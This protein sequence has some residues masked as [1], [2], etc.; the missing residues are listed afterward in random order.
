MIKVLV[1]RPLFDAFVGLCRFR[2][3][4]HDKALGT[5]LRGFKHGSLIDRLRHQPP[6][7]ML[8]LLNRRLRQ[9]ASPAISA[10]MRVVAAVT[11]EFP[12]LNRPGGKA[13]HHTHWLF[14]MQT[15]N[16]D[17]LMRQLWSRRI[18]AT[19][20]AS[21]LT[22]VS[23]PAGRV[24]ATQAER[25]MSEVLYLP[26]CPTAT[27]AELLEIARAVKALENLHGADGG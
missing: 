9:S 6:I 18:D 25:F 13:A 8:R 14:P 7:G 16:P 15:S 23:A 2:G 4:D 20:G 24:P 21:N 11:A 1:I 12:E 3:V 22:S 5:A 19:C 27:N 17:R 10:R 26:L